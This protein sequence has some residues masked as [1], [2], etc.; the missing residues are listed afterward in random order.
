MVTRSLSLIAALTLALGG[1]LPAAAR[2]EPGAA[3]WK[4]PGLMRSFLKKASAPDRLLLYR[5]WLAMP[6]VERPA[7]SEEL[8]LALA[9]ELASL[10]LPKAREI[11]DLLPKAMRRSR[12]FWPER[13]E[14]RG[15]LVG[16]LLDRPEAELVSS[17]VAL[18]PLVPPSLPPAGLLLTKRRAE[19][20]LALTA[21]GKR[22]LSD[23]EGGALWALCWASIE[24]GQANPSAL[25]LAARIVSQSRYSAWTWSSRIGARSI[26]RAAAAL[27]APALPSEQAR[28]LSILAAATRIGEDGS[29]SFE[30]SY[31]SSPAVKRLLDSR[32]KP[33]GAYGDDEEA[34]SA[35]LR[36]A[37]GAQPSEAELL[38]LLDPDRPA[39]AAAAA[40]LLSGSRSP[41][42]AAAL[43]ALLRNGAARDP[44]LL[45]VAMRALAANLGAGA[46]DPVAG[47]CEDPA[48]EVREAACRCLARLGDAGALPALLGRLRDPDGAARLAAIEGLGRLRG[49]GAV[50]SLGAILLSPEE[51]GATKRAC[52]KSLGA[53]GGPKAFSALEAFLLSPQ[54][55]SGEEA[56]ARSY[57][58]ISLGESGDGS[59]ADSLLAN[60]DPR[61]EADLNYHCIVALGRIADPAGL[62][63]LLP[64]AQKGLPVW[65]AAPRTRT[66]SAVYW[67]LLSLDGG[68][69]RQ[70]YLDRWKAAR[71]ASSDKADAA[72]WFAALYLLANSPADGQGASADRAAWATCVDKE[73]PRAIATDCRMAGEALSRYPFPA[74]L[75]RAASLLSTLDPYSKSW[76]A[77]SLVHHPTASM[78]PALRALLDCEDDYLAY[79]ALA[80]MDNLV[81]L[82]PASL[83]PELRARLADF[84]A[85]IAGLSTAQVAGRTGEWRDVVGKRLDGL[86]GKP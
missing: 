70:F 32:L 2:A 9:A 14:A 65:M 25:S 21:K 39:Q 64:L 74:L 18:C 41:A 83:D 17:A 11:A 35:L 3:D 13:G 82:L 5:S 23:S 79:A 42:A 47:L 6:S 22:P 63:R 45:V 15:E 57:A 33:G 60:I 34:G 51:D 10:D 85:R 40:S 76:I 84:R 55:G 48:A 77:S 69:A 72:A 80:S 19:G 78:I 8:G 12:T 29:I 81:P 24:R 50:D 26:D 4:E 27:S 38:A 31:A 68:P 1:L 86:L 20:I 37:R 61:R 43:S 52:A 73:L 53:L 54:D 7:V 46:V 56:A 59:A 58:A 36:S 66:P 44:F 71:L 16:A 49:Q 62:R 75:D 30:P 67:A 28:L